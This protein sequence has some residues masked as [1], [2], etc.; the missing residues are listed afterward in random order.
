MRGSQATIEERVHA[1]PPPQTT[2]AAWSPIRHDIDAV[3]Q[4]D[5][6]A[7]LLGTSGELWEYEDGRFFVTDPEGDGRRR[8]VP[9]GC[10]V[11]PGPWRHYA[12]CDCEVCRL[13]SA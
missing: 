7:A 9:T 6:P 12:S 1:A 10:Y 3:R 4:I 13:G 8:Y 2:D 11:P 5:A